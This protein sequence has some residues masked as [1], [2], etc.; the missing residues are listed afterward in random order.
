MRQ[1]AQQ[2]AA[3]RRK[4]DPKVLERAKVVAEG[5]EIYDREAAQKVVGEFLKGKTRKDGG[6][7]QQELMARM[8]GVKH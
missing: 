3:I 5:G 2:A 1:I 8:R 6:V 7:F 4:L